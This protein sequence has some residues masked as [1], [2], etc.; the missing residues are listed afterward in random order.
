M[1]EKLTNDNVSMIFLV[2]VG[3]V[4]VLL[5]LTYLNMR[6]YMMGLIWIFWGFG[7]VKQKA[8]TKYLA[9]TLLIFGSIVASLG[10]Y[11]IPSG[12]TCGITCA[13]YRVFITTTGMAMFLGGV[14]NLFA[15]A[16]WKVKHK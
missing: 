3:A 13:R 9:V 8:Y 2:V 16:L 12:V 4:T 7:Y 15:Y 6:F 1:K 5:D 14:V 11:L 10:W